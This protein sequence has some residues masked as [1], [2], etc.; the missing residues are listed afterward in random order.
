[1]T[2]AT[3]VTGFSLLGHLHR[4]LRASRTAAAVVGQVVAGDPATLRFNL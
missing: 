3:D 1:M 4:M 2:A